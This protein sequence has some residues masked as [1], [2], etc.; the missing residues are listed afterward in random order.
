MKLLLIVIF[1][2]FPT[3]SEAQKSIEVHSDLFTKAR[4]LSIIVNGQNRGITPATLSLQQ[5]H[6][7]DIELRNSANN[8]VSRFEFRIK[9]VQ[10]QNSQA[11]LPSWYRNPNTLQNKYSGMQLYSSIG[12]SRS[13]EISFNKAIHDAVRKAG[14][15]NAID[16][17]GLDL[18]VAEV[19]ITG[20]YYE[21]YLLMGKRS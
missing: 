10:P 6:N 19:N 14:G 4:D 7:Y 3:F 1:L 11:S 5:G 20:N 18:L 2:L 15:S 8:K 21:V 17:A 13:M 12:K 9:E 16:A